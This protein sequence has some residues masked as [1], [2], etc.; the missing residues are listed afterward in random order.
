[1]KQRE[2]MARQTA[3]SAPKITAPIVLSRRNTAPA[4]ARIGHKPAI[5]PARSSWPAPTCMAT[6][7]ER[8]GSSTR[9]L[10]EGS[11]RLEPAGQG[12]DVS[13]IVERRQPQHL[14]TC[15]FTHTLVAT[16]WNVL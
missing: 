10:D 5:A 7:V 9:S 14:Q 13:Q 15:T 3:S 6:G 1:M 12:Q 16:L 2:M 11:A 8:W 4:Q